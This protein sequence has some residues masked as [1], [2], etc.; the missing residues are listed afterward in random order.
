M[1]DESDEESACLLFVP[2]PSWS[3][4]KEMSC[5]IS[6]SIPSS[7][8]YLRDISASI[9]LINCTPFIYPFHLPGILPGFEMFV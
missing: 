5:D 6:S 9:A 3:D 4:L 8:D 1:S 7:L 2:E